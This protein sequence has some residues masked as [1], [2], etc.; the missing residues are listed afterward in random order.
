MVFRTYRGTTGLSIIVFSGVYENHRT[1]SLSLS[2]I[3][4][5]LLCFADGSSSQQV[6]NHTSKRLNTHP[7]DVELKTEFGGILL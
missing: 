6:L 4:T 5:G 3:P 1:G 2:R 7:D